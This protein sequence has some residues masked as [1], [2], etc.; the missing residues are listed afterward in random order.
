MEC[1]FNPSQLMRYEQTLRSFVSLLT[2]EKIPPDGPP[3]APLK[4]RNGS[5]FFPSSS[6]GPS[7]C[8]GE[9]ITEATPAIDD[10]IANKKAG[11]GSSPMLRG[12]LSSYG[13][14]FGATCS[15]PSLSTSLPDAE[16]K[17][18]PSDYG[19]DA[20]ASKSGPNPESEGLS[21]HLLRTFL[22][23]G[24]PFPPPPG[25]GGSSACSKGK[26]KLQR[27]GRRSGCVMGGATDNVGGRRQSATMMLA[28]AAAAVAAEEEALAAIGDEVREKDGLRNTLQQSPQGPADRMSSPL[29]YT[30]EPGSSSSKSRLATD[31]VALAPHIV[32]H[33]ICETIR[34]MINMRMRSH[35]SSLI[36]RTIVSSGGKVT[37]GVARVLAHDVST[38][39]DGGQVTLEDDANKNKPLANIKHE[40]KG[41]QA[42][43]H[44]NMLWDQEHQKRG[45][46]SDSRKDLP[47]RRLSPNIKKPKESSVSASFT[48]SS[49]FCC[50]SGKPRK[51][52]RNLGASWLKKQ[53]TSRAVPTKHPAT[54]SVLRSVTSFNIPSDAKGTHSKRR[55]S[56]PVPQSRGDQQAATSPQDKGIEF[57]SSTLSN[58]KFGSNPRFASRITRVELP[59]TFAT[60]VSIEMGGRG[61]GCECD[62]EFG[63]SGVIVGESAKV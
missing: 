10:I 15:L 11:I 57:P 38:E 42:E 17:A 13:C 2:V 36:S 24:N 54:V 59:L 31:D 48:N 9:T 51:V 3:N 34:Q 44:T 1:N 41:L 56:R 4:T 40:F 60:I 16:F 6:Q 53:Q 46:D 5:D 52:P 58:D 7:G 23:R 45:L 47:R 55:L 61:S 25:S 29:R 30:T 39:D 49:T 35:L 28:A 26:K 62:L 63:T 8:D 50:F 27:H 37:E 12:F 32:N 20:P 18:E 21:M 22:R 14:G 33:N 19:A 43:N